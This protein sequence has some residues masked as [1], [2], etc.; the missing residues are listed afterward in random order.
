MSL[1]TAAVAHMPGAGTWSLMAS[2]DELSGAHGYALD[3]NAAVLV[4][5]TGLSL[6]HWERDVVGWNGHR[7]HNEATLYVGVG[8][9][10]LIQVQRGFS[11]AGSRTRLRSDIVFSEDFPLP[12]D[13]DNRG[14]FGKGIAVSFFIEQ[15][16]GRKVYGL[17]LGFGFR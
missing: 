1:S 7:H 2:R 15:A 11:N 10:N 17:G 8:F 12:S 13:R 3:A 9:L 4:I 6:R 14:R 16:S 5:N